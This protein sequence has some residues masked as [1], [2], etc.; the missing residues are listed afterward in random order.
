MRALPELLPPFSAAAQ[1]RWRLRFWAGLLTGLVFIAGVLYFSILDTLRPEGFAVPVAVYVCASAAEG[2]GFL[3]FAITARYRSRL[4]W[5]LLNGAAL[6]SSFGVFVLATAHVRWHLATPTAAVLAVLAGLAA[7]MFGVIMTK[8][9]S[10]QALAW[11]SRWPAGRD[12]AADLDRAVQRAMG[13]RRVSADQLKTAR[14]NRARAA[15]ARSRSDD[16]PDGLVEAAQELRDLL[17]DPPDSW[18]MLFGAALDLTDAMA[19][20]VG[21]HGDLGGYRTALQLLADTAC[22]MPADLGAM[23]IVYS[24]RADYH[25][26]LADRATSGPEVDEHAGA[27]IANL[28][29]AISATTP[30]LR[31]TLPDVHAKLGLYVARFGAGPGDLDAGIEL[32]RA[33]V[34]LAGPWPRA[35][36]RPEQRLAALLIDRAHQTAEEL[37]PDAGE[38]EIAAAVTAVNRALA[39]AE[40]LLRHAHRHGLRD[41]RPWVI[42]Q[43]AEAR[44]ARSTIFGGLAHDRRAARAWRA[45]VSSA[46]RED[47]MDRMD[48][49][50]D[51][52]AWAESVQDVTWCAEAYA[53]LMSVVA[54]AVAVRY[55]AGERDRVLASVQSAAEE[56]GYWLA[57][58]G[59]TGDAA[60]ALELGRA[61][62]L[63]EIIG[64]ERPDLTAAL[65][66][67]GREDLLDRYRGAVGDLGATAAPAL[68]DDLS[69]ADQRAW[70]RYDAVVRDIAAVVD[71][72]LPGVPPTLA[73][74]ALAAR[75]GPIVYL[76][77]AARGGYAI[78]VPAAGPPVYR[79]LPGLTRDRIAGQVTSFLPNPGPAEVEAVVRWLW[80]AGVS[81]LAQDLPTGA[82]VTV[83]PVGRLSLLPVHAAGGPAM[84]GQP[85]ADWTYLAD[86]VTIR[87]AH[88]AR[89]LL[90]ARERS[91]RFTGTALTLLGVA[92]AGDPPCEAPLR[93]ASREVALIARRWAR[94]DTVT[95]GTPDVV[96]RM[97]ED[98][99]VWHFACHCEVV[100]DSILDS[101]LLLR[102]GPLSLR[103][104]L[105]LAPSPRRLALLSACET[106]ISD[107]R[108]PD[109][110]MGMPAG[111]LQA[112]FA[113]VVASHWQVADRPTAYFMIRFHELW[114]EQG[115]APAAAVA[116]AQRS[117]RAAS[118]TEL[119]A[120]LNGKRGGPAD[121]PA[122][123]AGSPAAHRTYG[124]PFFWASFALTGC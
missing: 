26:T 1:R 43:L 105:A 121:G 51:W 55:L 58:A 114:H 115:L 50:K 111:L 95:D 72:D 8:R 71:I 97:L 69:S 74:L 102:G 32:C 42:E 90:R 22:R 98:H 31:A 88:N 64:R 122:L 123:S 10:A 85:S 45:A 21:K 11:G 19:V 63:S 9:S 35:R 101:A 109:E 77:G 27:A 89:T 81:A 41:D 25:A 118:P 67:A 24:R 107:T 75:D 48:I 12:G 44:T 116:E 93:H 103:A 117:L 87:Y 15:I 91:E 83:V 99:N 49:G 23:A 108:L 38:P 104:I 47:P 112:G 59:R 86:R 20:K 80:E 124:H 34:H 92:S 6:A 28:R 94:A 14:L 3:I 13:S 96:E 119:T 61:V 73:E 79:P 106:H 76:A 56:A 4:G 40:R 46:A 18:M 5:H 110:A 16:A 120:C 57:E 84:A 2:W 39:E 29:A 33:A 17:A 113:G 53:Y 82:L 37:D 66:R 100:P 62:S 60:V 78:V 7:G 36:A 30:P 70:A 54:P 52:V 65:T 68:D